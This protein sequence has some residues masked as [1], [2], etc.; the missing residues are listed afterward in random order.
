M[1][2]VSS[3]PRYPCVKNHRPPRRFC[4]RRGACRPPG[5]RTAPPHAGRYRHPHGS[6][7]DSVLLQ[8]LPLSLRCCAAVAP[9]GGY[10]EGF[11][12]P[13]FA[14][15]ADGADQLVKLRNPTA[16]HRQCQPLAPQRLMVR[17]RGFQLFAQ[18]YRNILDMLVIESLHDPVHG[19]DGDLVRPLE[20]E[21]QFGKLNPHFAAHIIPPFPSPCAT[22][23]ISWALPL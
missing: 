15:I 14:G 23:G 3:D 20:R 4:H 19:W 1:A 21:V 13:F 10:D 11:R 7:R 18:P 22:S 6:R 5:L 8:D 2:Q 12:P 16:A 9:H 17:Y